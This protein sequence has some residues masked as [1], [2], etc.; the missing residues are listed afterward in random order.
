MLD[1][2][3]KEHSLKV[4]ALAVIASYVQLLGYG[5][6]FLRAFWKRMILRKGEFSAYNKTFYK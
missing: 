1:A 5:T 2:S 4:G 3:I 6:G